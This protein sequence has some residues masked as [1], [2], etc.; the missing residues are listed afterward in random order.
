MEAFEGVIVYHSTNLGTKS[1]GK[2]PF[3]YRGNGEF[4]R[5]WKKGDYSF[6]GDGLKSYDQQA[7]VI[8]GSVDE[9]DIF[10]VEEISLLNENE[11]DTD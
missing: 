2:H 4:L 7:V 5:I 3:L 11:V 9:N 10:I 1:A 6:E 8:K